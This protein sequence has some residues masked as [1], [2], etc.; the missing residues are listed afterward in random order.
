MTFFVKLDMLFYMDTIKF[1]VI[2]LF[3]PLLII[4]LFGCVYYECSL[5]NL[6]KE[7]QGKHLAMMKNILTQQN[8]TKNN[9]SVQIKIYTATSIREVL[10]KIYTSS[11]EEPE[12]AIKILQN[13][14][15]NETTTSTPIENV[16]NFHKKLI[17][18]NNEAFNTLSSKTKT[19]IQNHS[20]LRTIDSEFQFFADFFSHDMSLNLTERDTITC[21][22]IHGFTTRDMCPCCFTHMGLF[23][24]R[25]KEALNGP[26]SV[27]G[28]SL[29]YNF[30]QQIKPFLPQSTQVQ[31]AFYISSSIQLGLQEFDGSIYPSYAGM[32]YNNSVKNITK[33]YPQNEQSEGGSP[34]EGIFCTFIRDDN[35]NWSL[36]YYAPS[37]QK[38]WQTKN[39]SFPNN[40]S[41]LSAKVAEQIKCSLNNGQTNCSFCNHKGKLKCSIHSEGRVTPGK[42]TITIPTSNIIYDG[43]FRNLI[44]PWIT[45]EVFSFAKAKA[46]TII[47]QESPLS[48]ESTD[49]TLNAFLNPSN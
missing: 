45:Q 48:I 35:P 37:Q 20:N 17:E 21:I 25:L 46:N 23:Y 24:D 15:K 12:N 18:S 5:K 38:Q 36:Q 29:F 32:T 16:Q 19:Y 33:F 4:N 30:I 47:I 2:F 11:S 3:L 10:N 41:T 6:S 42:Y 14:W 31:L 43:T 40:A 39:I 34:T 7:Q 44:S 22:E 28:N 13:L 9:F 1:K 49:L 8:S 27:N 26:A